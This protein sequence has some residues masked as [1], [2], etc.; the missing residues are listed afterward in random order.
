M[1]FWIALNKKLIWSC[2]LL[3]SNILHTWRVWLSELHYAH[4]L[5]WVSPS[6]KKLEQHLPLLTHNSAFKKSVQTNGLPVKKT[7]NASQPFKTVKRNV[8]LSNHAGN[9]AFLP[10]EVKLP[11][12]LLNVL[13]LTTAF[14]VLRLKPPQLP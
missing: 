1:E 10:K 14:K 13:P 3:L 11:L 5:P 2:I 8:E 6:R 12:M 9:S 7:L 4:H